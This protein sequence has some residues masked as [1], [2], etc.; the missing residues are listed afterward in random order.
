MKKTAL[1]VTAMVVAVLFSSCFEEDTSPKKSTPT[2][3]SCVNWYYELLASEKYDV[4]YDYYFSD[5]SKTVISKD[6]Y[7]ANIKTELFSKNSRVI[8]SELIST[9]NVEYRDEEIIKIN[10]LVRYNVNGS[11]EIESVDDY[12]IKQ[13]KDGFYKLLYKE[14][15]SKT[16]YNMYLTQDANSVHSTKAVL[17]KKVGGVSLDYVFKNTLSKAFSFGKP[18]GK[19]G[20]QIEYQTET[21][22]VFYTIEKPVIM[23]TGEEIMLSAEFKGVYDDPIRIVVYDIYELGNDGSV[24]NSN[25]P[26]SYSVAFK[27]PATGETTTAESTA[28]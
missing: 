10:S 24:L 15:V 14:I 3:E 1:L 20:A 8:A 16:D 17:Y 7:V 2:P 21:K 27:P 19:E 5:I 28:Q 22:S 11:E 12:L 13:K 25:A 18:D 23:K 26:Q 4:A 9:E 6:N